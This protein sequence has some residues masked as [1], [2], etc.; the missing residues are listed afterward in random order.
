MQHALC[1][2]AHASHAALD[3]Q[4]ANKSLH[5]QDQALVCSQRKWLEAQQGDRS[6]KS[7][8]LEPDVAV[9]LCTFH[10]CES[11][12]GQNR[13]TTQNTYTQIILN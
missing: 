6:P 3:R 11:S 9:Q 2:A 8:D 13:D 5:R 7:Y 10:E 4:P 1:V 12:S